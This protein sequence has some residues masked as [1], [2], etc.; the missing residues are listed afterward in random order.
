MGFGGCVR[1]YSRRWLIA[2]VAAWMLAS[3]CS[4]F[5]TNLSL[6]TSSSS[7]SFTSPA[8]QTAGGSDF[9]LTVTGTGF[10]TGAFILWNGTELADTVFVSGS[11]MTAVIPAAD[12]ATPGPIQVSVEIP[13]S[14]VSATS[15]INNTANYAN[16]T[17]VSNFVYFNINAAPGP[18]PVISSVSAST[19]GM[20]ATPYCSPNGFTLT[21][22]GSNFTSGAVVN[23]TSATNPST[24][25]TARVTNLVSSTQLTAAILP[26]DTAFPGT[27]SVS[28]SNASGTSTA[29]QV[30]MTTPSSSLPAPS[31]TSMVQKFVSFNTA[32]GAHRYGDFA[33]SGFPH[34]HI[35][36]Q[37]QFFTPMFHCAV[38]PR[39]AGH[40]FCQPHSTQCDDSSLRSILR[41][42]RR[43]S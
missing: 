3:A 14:A 16:T 2:A 23:W 19:T 25:G 8:T 33:A 42:S 36:S 31:I 12:I 38:W 35:G 1:M 40:R 17:E 9:T 32:R 21:V 34:V 6:Q 18:L 41:R 20:A 11:T 7:V 5:N 39:R 30:T 28:V 4:Q 24:I 10:V 22:N 13:G 15:N 43:H 27:A 29:V 37:W 26:S